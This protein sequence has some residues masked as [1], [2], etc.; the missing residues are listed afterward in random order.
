MNEPGYTPSPGYGELLPHPSPI[1]ASDF[2]AWF[3]LFWA[4]LLVVVLALPWAIRRLVQFRDTLPILMLGA[5][6]GTSLGEPMLDLVGHLRWSENLLGPAFVNFGIPVPVLIPPC[7]MLFMGLEAYWIWMIIQRGIDVKR[8]FLMFAAVGISDAVM[9]HPGVIMGVYEYY[10]TQPLEFY[11]FPFYW[12]FTNGVAICT[13]A[14]LVHYVWPLVKDNGRQ[15]LWIIPLGIIGTTMGEFGSGFPVF[16]AIN[17][18]IPTWL[19]WAIG[20]LTVPLSLLWIRVLAELVATEKSV[21]WT[22]WGL[23]KSRFMT[24]KRREQYIRGI[25]WD[26]TYEPKLPTWPL[27]NWRS[28]SSAAPPALPEPERVPADA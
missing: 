16:L 13:I 14:V 25:G 3:F 23:F 18:D 28:T 6:L 17:A 21:E 22:F 7:Y 1:V 15:Q 12:S 11:K 10:G 5:G 19:Q 2:S 20:C 4:G 27:N 24:P 8:F 9:E 26:E